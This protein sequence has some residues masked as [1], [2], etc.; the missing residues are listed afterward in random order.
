MFRFCGAGMSR[1]P[2]NT[3]RPSA[4]LL[5]LSTWAEIETF[6]ER[7]KAGVIPIGSYQQHGPAGP[8]GT[9]PPG[10][11]RHATPSEIAVPQWAY[12]D[13]IKNANYAPQIAP[14][15]PIREAS[16]FRA[17]FADGRMG[18]DPGLATPEKGGELVKLAAAGLV[19]D[20]AAFASE[21][22]PAG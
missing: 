22:A 3:W 16:A 15:G 21:V 8:F 9:D 5:H 7:S 4:L 10:P 12:P 1:G 2:S 17:R 19:E 13:A 14:T 20:V 11:G 18:S 6:L